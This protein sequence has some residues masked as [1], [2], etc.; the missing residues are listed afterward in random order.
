MNNIIIYLLIIVI[1]FAI[2]EYFKNIEGMD[3]SPLSLYM[4]DTEFLRGKHAVKGPCISDQWKVPY[5]PSAC[6]KYDDLLWHYIEPRK[7]LVDN[8]L[9]C[10]ACKDYNYVA[11]E[12][13]GGY[14]HNKDEFIQPD[15]LSHF[16]EHPHSMS[17]PTGNGIAPVCQDCAMKKGLADKGCG[18]SKKSLYIN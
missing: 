6:G 13:I 17:A 18:C 4:Q 12:G 1:V 14:D 2:F 11:P 10:N 8:Q 5:A 9:N 3:A 16:T 7:I 15:L